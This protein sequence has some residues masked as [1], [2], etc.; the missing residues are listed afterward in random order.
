VELNLLYVHGSEIGYGRD[1]L[2]RM[3]AAGVF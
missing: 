2:A 3:K 1:A